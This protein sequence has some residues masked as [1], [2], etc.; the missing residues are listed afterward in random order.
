MFRFLLGMANGCKSPRSPAN[1]ATPTIVS[2]SPTA[3]FVSGG[4]FEETILS[5]R[6][7][8]NM[9]AATLTLLRV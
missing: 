1:V 3:A 5:K 8:F 4:A 7:G 6:E 2:T 9:F